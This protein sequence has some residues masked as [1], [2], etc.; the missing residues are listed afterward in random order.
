M[1]QQ[2]VGCADSHI[3]LDVMKRSQLEIY[4]CNV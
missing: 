3:S 4:Q 1:R 2:L